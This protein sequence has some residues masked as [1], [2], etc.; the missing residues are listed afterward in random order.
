MKRVSILIIFLLS[1]LVSIA[2]T[3]LGYVKTLGRPEKKGEALSGVSIRVKGEHNSVLSNENGIFSLLLTGKKNGDAYTLQHVQKLGYELNESDVIG[4][5]HAFSE[6]VPLTLV[7][8][9]SAQ[10]QADKLRIENKAYQVAENNYKNLLAS[11][12]TQKQKQLITLEQYRRKLQELQG[13]FENYQSMIS[14]LAEHYAHTDYDQLDE[15]DREI[16]FCIENGN[17][18]RADSLIRSL[19]NPVDVLK[20]NNESLYRID[21]NILQAGDILRQANEAMSAV[22]KRQSKDAEYLY[23]L[24]TISLARFDN[25]KAAWYIETRAQL[26]TTNVE[27]QLE[28]GNFFCEYLADYS[29]AMMLF[30]KALRNAVDQSGEQHQNVAYCYSNIGIVYDKES[31]YVKAL[32]FYEKSLKIKQNIFGEQHYSVAVGYNN[33][34]NVYNSQ[35]KYGEA[36]KY[37]KKALEIQQFIYG[38][39]HQDIATSYNNIGNVISVH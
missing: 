18:E 33:I 38:E 31:N 10:L 36:L 22:L 37:L 8:V 25:Q 24:Y 2:Q 13:R 6:K 19:F 26:D 3:Q 30:K 21:Q 4:R 32:E 1:L 12:E 27:W 16:N 39:H 29:K 28:A 15:N 20:R 35:G 14:S 17:L 11:L 7:M 9:S 5:P 23:Q 34:G